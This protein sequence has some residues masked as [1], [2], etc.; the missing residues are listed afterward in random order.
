M[1]RTVESSEYASDFL[2]LCTIFRPEPGSV[3]FT[4]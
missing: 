3:G 1:H 4:H 2:Q